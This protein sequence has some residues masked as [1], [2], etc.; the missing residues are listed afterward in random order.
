MLQS[1]SVELTRLELTMLIEKEE[2]VASQQ[3]HNANIRAEL[4]KM[5]KNPELYEIFKK[6]ADV[7]RLRLRHAPGAAAAASIGGRRGAGH[8]Q[9]ADMQVRADIIGHARINM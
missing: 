4:Y 5:Q 3:L 9:W 1:A 8:A 6:Q 7:A 2:S